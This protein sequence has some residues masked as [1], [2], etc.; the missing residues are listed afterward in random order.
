MYCTPPH[1]RRVW[2]CD[3]NQSCHKMQTKKKER[4]ATE[5]EHEEEE[6]ALSS[7]IMVAINNNFIASTVTFS[8]G[9][10]E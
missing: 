2:P 1:Q 8:L 6:G 5:E 7:T 3:C 4:L 9:D 10:G